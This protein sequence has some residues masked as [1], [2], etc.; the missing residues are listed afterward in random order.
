MELFE[1]IKKYF[2]NTFKINDDEFIAC[3]TH[4]TG[5]LSIMIA[6]Y[7]HKNQKRRND[8][9]YIS[10][11]MRMLNKYEDLI[12]TKRKNLSPTF[13]YKMNESGLPYYGIEELI[14]LHDV[15]EDTSI[16]II[17]LENI[18]KENNFGEYFNL[19]IKNPLLLLT[20]NKKEDYKTYIDKLLPSKEASFVKLLDMYDNL[21]LL[22]V[23]ILTKDFE[24]KIKNYLSFSLKIINFHKFNE[25]FL[26]YNE[27][28]KK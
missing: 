1:N 15:I 23:G 26:K 27:F 20:H 16:T 4:S 8:E 19:Y 24:E 3:Y 18:F 7:A 28:R 14:L 5:Y 11:P 2:K 12:G 10:H 9:P 25:S 6:I 17:D 21:N 13:I 22:S